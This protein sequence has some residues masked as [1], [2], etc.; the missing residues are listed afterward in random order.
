MVLRFV[1]LSLCFSFLNCSTLSDEERIAVQAMKAIAAGDWPSYEKLTVTTADFVMQQN[2]KTSPTKQ[3]YSGA[4]LKPRQKERQKLDFERAV[5]SE[6]G[7][8]NFKQEE[9]RNAVLLEA[10]SYDLLTG[11]KISGN[12]FTTNF[13][14]EQTKK[15]A[16]VV[17]PWGDSY[18]ILGLKFD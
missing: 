18:R 5:S 15:P 1:V 8:L 13:Y 4:V 11:E 3:S 7:F 10:I 6:A 9:I 2:K 14:T 17:V 16:L 12:L